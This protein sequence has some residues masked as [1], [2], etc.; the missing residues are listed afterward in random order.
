MRAIN[1]S[2]RK[3]KEQF[4]ETSIRTPS[5]EN[6]EGFSYFFTID[7]ILDPPRY[8]G[9]TEKVGDQSSIIEFMKLHGEY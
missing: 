2:Y 7:D 3:L 1:E 8:T 4:I 5:R 9:E 6:N